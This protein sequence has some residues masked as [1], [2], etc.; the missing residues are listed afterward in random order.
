MAKRYY[1][2]ELPTLLQPPPLLTEG[3]GRQPDA[4]CF[5]GHR[6]LSSAEKQMLCVRLDKLIEA[7]W[8]RDYRTFICGGA[9]GFDTL[10]AQRVLAAKKRH[11][12]LRLV[13]ALPCADQSRRWS[14]E[15]CRVYE[16]LLYAADETHVISPTYFDGCMQ[17]RNRFMVDHAS[18]C[19]C[20]LNKM[21]GG[22]VSTVA[23]ALREKCPVLNVAMEDACAAYLREAVLT[24]SPPS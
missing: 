10:V 16:R 13:M 8:L 1:P 22:T 4:V 9:L 24:C 21:K 6:L 23:Y 3:H 11:P 5:T 17:V 15:D 12:E 18:L 14:S 7:L 19:V 2:A 20:Y